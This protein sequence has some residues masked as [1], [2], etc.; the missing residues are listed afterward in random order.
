MHRLGVH[1]IFSVH[2]F[3]PEH[4]FPAAQGIPVELV[5]PGGSCKLMTGNRGKRVEEETVYDAACL[6]QDERKEDRRDK[7]HGG[8]EWNERESE[9]G[10]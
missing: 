5:Q 3:Q 7:R 2:L 10:H 4:E 6:G 9:D 8:R 1:T